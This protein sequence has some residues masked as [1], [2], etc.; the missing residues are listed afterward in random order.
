MMHDHDFDLIADIAQGDMSPDEQRTAEASLCETCRV[1]LQ[2]QREALEI[3]RS[4]PP[5]R[6]SE[7][8]R[9]R[10]RRRVTETLFPPEPAPKPSPPWFQRL[11]PAM[12]AA[13]A[14]LFVVGVGSVLIN[15]SGESD[16]VVQTTASAEKAAD[17][18]SFRAGIEGEAGE[19]PGASADE[20][21]AA[22]EV[23]DM[24]GAPT[25]TIAA[26]EPTALVVED[27][28]AI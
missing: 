4:S 8:E 12:A 13:A 27:F 17:E 9:A 7:L 3:L 2:L 26:S 14:L 18:E 25:T 24:A 11:V 6:L 21:P 22:A 10:V 20:A 23:E 5:V 1:E 28:G 15:P 16:T 19:A